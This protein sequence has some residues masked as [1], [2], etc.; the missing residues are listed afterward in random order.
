M[1]GHS[2]AHWWLL[3]WLLT[4]I[5]LPAL[6]AVEAADDKATPKQVAAMPQMAAPQASV[7]GL[8]VSVSWAASL[9]ETT[10]YQLEVYKNDYSPG[11]LRMEKNVLSYSFTGEQGAKYQFQT[12][13]CNAVTCSVYSPGSNVVW[14]GVNTSPP[15]QPGPPT[16]SLNGLSMT[17]SWAASPNA[18]YYLFE[19][20]R[21]GVATGQL[22]LGNVLSYS[23]TADASAV[24]QFQ[25]KACNSFGCSTYSPGSN[26]I[27]VPSP[28]PKQSA[29]SATNS[30]QS[31]TVRWPAAPNAT[32]YLYEPYLNDYPT[33]QLNLGNTLSYTFT[34]VAGGKYQFLTKACNLYGCSLYSPESNVLYLPAAQY[35][36]SAS[37]GSNG[38]IS[39]AFRDVN[40]GQQT[41]FTVTANQGFIASASGCGGSL[42]GNTFTTG[43]I[44][45]ACT[46]QASFSPQSYTVSTSVGAGGSMTPTSRTVSHGQTT[47]FT[48]S[49]NSGFVA[50]VS[51]CGG[52][53]NGN[54]YT[55]GAITANCTVSAQFS[56]QAVR[57]SAVAGANGSINPAYRDIQRGQSTTFT[58]APNSG[59]RASATGCNGTLSGNTYTTGAVETPC[60]VTASFSL[61]SSGNVVFLHTDVLGSVVAESDS[62]GNLQKTTDHKPFGE[63]KDN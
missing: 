6:A 14:A 31:V 23:F 7:N 44:S 36:V 18:T 60:T 3:L 19:P 33:G 4:T 57:V 62:N 8:T 37:A 47:S 27:T 5:A 40:Q 11:F 53:L 61:A 2:P 43:A 30:G 50:L 51:G 59:Y 35:R 24:Y 38:S 56:N 42:S 16:A 46:V 45:S 22:R 26:V 21:N 15:A 10:Y 49:P 17:V 39:P 58:L 48:L 1:S 32:Y 28:P 52:S 55:T 34:G 29:P 20:W 41:S 12:K 63:S 9:P 54:T 25:T 13:A